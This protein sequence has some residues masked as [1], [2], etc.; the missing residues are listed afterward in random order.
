MHAGRRILSWLWMPVSLFLSI[1]RSMTGASASLLLIAIVSLNIVWGYPWLGMFAA[2]S[3]LLIVGVAA[4]RLFGP[5]LVVQLSPPS[6]AVLGES[7]SVTM[8]LNHRGRLPTFDNRIGFAPKPFQLGV[9]HQQPITP[10]DQQGSQLISCIE[11]N[12]RLQTHLSLRGSER[13]IHPLPPIESRTL[14][15]FHLFECRRKW[16]STSSIA[17][18]PKPLDAE[19]DPM[20]GRLMDQ[21]SRWTQRWQ[22]GDSF[23]FAGNR[24]YEVGMPVRR[25]DFRSWARLGRPIVQE[26]QSP[27]MR[28]V[29]LIVDASVDSPTNSS[30]STKEQ[31]HEFEQLLRWVASVIDYWNRSSVATRMYVSSDPVASFLDAECQGASELPKLMFQLASARTIEAKESRRRIETVLGNVDLNSVVL[32]TAGNPL[33]RDQPTQNGKADHFNDDQDA[34]LGQVNIV[35]YEPSLE[36]QSQAHWDTAKKET[37]S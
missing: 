17:I 36:P 27:S 5:R 29:T 19:N 25:W 1:R 4:N 11:A 3:T 8:H 23:D 20:F 9:S 24:E 2:T 32:F 10:C 21:M 37:V 22:S 16:N 13:G 12:S 15:P 6:Y 30:K 33:Q 7:F 28:T 18:A 35:Q 31:Q 26:F 14:F 34:L